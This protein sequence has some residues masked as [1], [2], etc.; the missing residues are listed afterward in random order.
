M[1]HYESPWFD[2]RFRLLLV[3]VFL[4]VN[5]K[6][7][8]KISEVIHIVIGSVRY[9][10]GTRTRDAGVTRRASNTTLISKCAGIWRAPHLT[11]RFSFTVKRWG[12]IVVSNS[13]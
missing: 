12:P 13:W 10:P 8:L 1:L 3:R 9:R 4:W 5:R 11:L 6:T 7:E 2:S